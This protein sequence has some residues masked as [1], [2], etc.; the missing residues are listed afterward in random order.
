MTP[1]ISSG[2]SKLLRNHFHWIW[3][4]SALTGEAQTMFC[5]SKK[6]HRLLNAFCWEEH[7]KDVFLFNSRNFLN[8]AHVEFVVLFYNALQKYSYLL[9][10]L[11]FVPNTTTGFK[12]FPWDFM[13]QN[14]TK[15]SFVKWK[16]KDRCYLFSPLQIKLCKVWC[17]FVFRTPNQSQITTFRFLPTSRNL[18]LCLHNNPSNTADWKDGIFEKQFQI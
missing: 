4:T 11:K 15:L 8:T 3:L 9:N 1:Y 13:W 12:T 7:L 16:Y 5:I 6:T 10:L 18:D 17:S 2:I 14:N